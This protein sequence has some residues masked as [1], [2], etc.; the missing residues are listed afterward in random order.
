MVAGAAVVRPQEVTSWL[1]RTDLDRLIDV[2]RSDGRTVIGPTVR[3]GAIVHAE[4]TSAGELPH[5]IR[6]EQA[7]GRYR[8]SPAGDD[9]AVRTFEFAASPTSWKAFTFPATV[10]LGKARHNEGDI[11]YEPPERELPQMAFL[12]V[13]ACDIAALRIH[14]DVLVGGPFVDQDYEARRS[15]VLIVAVE[16]ARPGGTCFCASMETGP[17]VREGFDLALTELDDGFVVRAGSE[18]GRDL[19]GRL[20]LEPADAAQLESAAAVPATAR[21]AMAGQPGVNVDGLH[22][23]L[24]GRLDDPHW[25]EIA[26][27]CLA[28]TNCTMVCPTCFC[29]S[30][31]QTSDLLGQETESQRQWASCFTLGFAQVAGGNFRPRLQDR[32]RQWLTHK[33][34]TWVDQFGTYGCVGC[35]RCV[36][37]CP[38]G[39]DVREEL[40]TLAPPVPDSEPVQRAGAAAA[41]L[42]RYSIGTVEHIRQE[43]VDTHTLTLTD[44]PE[45]VRAGAPGQFLMLDLPGFSDVPISVSRYREDGIELTIRAAGASTR[46]IT[47]LRPGSGVGLRGPLGR[48]WPTDDGHGSDVI[49][50]AGGIG[51][52]PLR[53]LIDAFLVARPQL[54]S[55]RLLYGARS[56]GDMLYTTELTRWQARDDM[57]VAVIVD[58]AEA[59]WTGSVGVVTQLIDRE[60]IDPTHTVAY[61]CGPEKMMIASWLS[62]AGRGLMPE[63]AYLSM[64][65]HMECGIGLCGHCQMGGAFVCKDG[66]V[67]SRRE[68]GDALVLE[69]I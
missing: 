11:T 26:E 57:R 4:I 27:R 61:I 25:A 32:Y 48:G 67:F 68:I 43:T 37:W 6:D 55:L 34:A 9:D 58:R 56:P 30:V 16:C 40:A 42:G 7:P 3:D 45:A 62:L 12:G 49:V 18:A 23:R 65:R 69:G 66:P 13:R 52:A 17:E 20:D 24:L 50:V 29:T 44:L 59:S 51:L 46:A 5:G 63:Q 39:I 53:P 15:R 2:L 41:G 54:R 14:D 60:D 28:C 36:T 21:A 1:P 8:I 33:F 10:S 31:S 64:E 22:D 35:G 19:A 38:V 47:S